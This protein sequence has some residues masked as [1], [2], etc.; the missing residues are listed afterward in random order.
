MLDGEYGEGYEIAMSVL[1]KLGDIYGADRMLRVENVHIDGAAY[2]WI[3]DSGLEL[4]EKLASSGARFRV[5]ATLNPSSIDFDMWQE[6]KVPSCIANEQLRLTNA[7]KR[8]GGIPTWTCA[9]YQ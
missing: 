6:L 8:M 2:G 4:V 9:P 7:L 5:P 1:V 3:N